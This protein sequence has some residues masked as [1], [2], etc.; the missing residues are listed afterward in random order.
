MS[1]MNMM[2]D[3]MMD[4]GVSM[5]GET[6]FNFTFDLNSLWNDGGL[7][8]TQMYLTLAECET[9]KG[10]YD[11]A[12]EYLDK[13]RVN[14]IDPAKYQPLQGTV[15]TKEE[16]IKH[17]K[18]VTMNEDIYSVNIFIDKKRWNQCDGW[19][20]NYSRTLAGKTYTITPDSKMWI[21][22]FP[23]S[24]INNNGNITQNYKE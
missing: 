23:Q 19:K 5:L 13:V 22:P 18:Q 17:V 4:A 21:F 6:G 15:S 2:Y 9:H 24:V 14:R 3:Y 8:S 20:Q 1:N 11:T 12:M 16:A 10:N 7:R